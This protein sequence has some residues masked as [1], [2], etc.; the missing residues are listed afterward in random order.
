M[1]LREVID[2]YIAWRQ[3]RGARFQSQAYALRRYSRGVGDAIGCDEVGSDQARAFLAAGATA[4]SNRAFLHSA[5]AG[6]YRY[7]IARGLATRSPLPAKPPQ[8]SQRTAP[9]IYTRAELRR[10]LDATPTYRQRVNQLE[11]PTFRALLLLLY[12][13][14]LRRGE[15]LRLTRADVDLRAALLTL[16]GTKFG[17]T[18][19]VPLAPPLARALQE[20]AARRKA[21][22]APQADEAPFFANRD[23]TPLAA[24]TVSKAFA[25]LRVAAGVVR[26]NATRQQPR[27]HDLRHSFAVHRLTAWHRQGADAQRLL[28]LLSTYL[29]HASVAATQVYLELT[30]ALL[31]AAA[32]RFERYAAGG[33]GGGHD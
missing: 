13:A 33:N 6:F 32:L 29:G 18:R 3:A 11:P 2:Q 9:Y 26:E 20:Y 8:V 22:G 7:A 23:G 19:Y 27:L 21:A 25:Q 5:L 30:P 14:G 24:R 10:L 28:P 31:E 16:R 15:A 17:K 12:G 4:A 1:T